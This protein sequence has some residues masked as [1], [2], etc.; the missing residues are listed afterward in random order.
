MI[1]GLKTECYL[2]ESVSEDLKSQAEISEN[3]AG[4][5]SQVPEFGEL[6]EHIIGTGGVPGSD[7]LL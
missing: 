1:P 5:V 4:D 7:S 3:C 2:K 6:R